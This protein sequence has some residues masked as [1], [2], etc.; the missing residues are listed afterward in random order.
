[1][2]Y[3]SNITKNMQF[4]KINNENMK[5]ILIKL[6]NNLDLKN[7]VGFIKNEE[8]LPSDIQT[9]L[10][11]KEGNNIM[12]YTKFINSTVKDYEIE[13]LFEIFTNDQ[14]HNIEKFVNS[15][16]KYEKYNNYF[17]EQFIKAQKES[18]FDYSIV[19]LVII[20][21]NKFNIYENAKNKCQNCVK[22]ILFHGSQIDPISQ[23]ISTEFKYTRKAYYGMGIY[24]TDILDYVL[25]YSGGKN[26]YDRRKYFNRILPPNSTFSLVASEVFYNKKLF[27]HIRNSDYKVPNLGHF[28]TYE[29]IETDYSDKM[30]PKNGIHYIT[31]NSDHGQVIENSIISMEEREKGKFIGNEYVITEKEQFCPIY[32]ITL[33]RNEYFVLWRDLN[34]SGS[35][36]YSEY[37]KRR[38]LF[39]NEIA[40]MNIYLEDTTENA[41]RFIHKRRYNKMIIITSIGLDLSGKKFI[42]ITRKILGFDIIILIYSKNKKHLSW[43]QSTPNLLYTNEAGIYQKYVKNYNENGLKELK[44]NVE[45]LYKIKLLDF[46]DDF[47]SY[48]LYIS[49]E[50][51]EKFSDIDCSEKCEYLR[52]VK[53]YNPTFKFYLIMNK[54]GS[55]GLKKEW[56]ESYAWDITLIN[57]ELTLFSNGY[58]LGVNEDLTKIISDKYMKYWDYQEFENFYVIKIKNNDKMISIYNDNICFSYYKTISKFEFIDI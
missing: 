17:E 44:A 57:N 53:I 43:I 15:L 34:F 8:K 23:I 5:Q 26:L 38:E 33:K 36:K 27:K 56:D 12:E 24:F 7:K 4:E 9:I 40:E 18:I 50:R 21:N 39:A 45:Q 48:P 32:G 2:K 54:D 47:L 35:N 20:D 14:K 51:D 16:I 19:N 1:M 31:V 6:K 58:Y 10:K 13:E 25:F 3:I 52:K 22:K 11:E 30:V 29:E 46:T 41:L 42:E 55:F 28:P 37:L 49:G